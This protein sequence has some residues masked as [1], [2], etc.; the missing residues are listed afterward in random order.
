MALVSVEKVFRMYRRKNPNL[1]DRVKVDRKIDEFLRLHF[2]EYS[3]WCMN[4]SDIENDPI[5]IYYHGILEDPQ[6]DDLTLIAIKKN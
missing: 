4:R 5:H 1:S 6:F 3:E 2:K